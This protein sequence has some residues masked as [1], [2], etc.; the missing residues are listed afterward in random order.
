MVQRWTG[1]VAASEA[2]GFV[3]YG[4]YLTLQEECN[5]LRHALKSLAQE[6]SKVADELFALSQDDGKIERALERANA[7]IKKMRAEL[8]LKIRKLKELDNANALENLYSVGLRQEN[9]LNALRAVL[10][11]LPESQAEMLQE[12][13]KL[14]AELDAQ[15]K[16][17]NYWMGEACSNHNAL[18]KLI[19]QEPV[20]KV[21]LTEKLSLPCLQWLDLTTQFTMLHGQLLYPAPGAQPVKA[22]WVMVPLTPSPEMIIAGRNAQCNTTFMTYSQDYIDLYKAMLTA[23]PK[24]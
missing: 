21:I 18:V 1:R 15:T 22:G 5:A 2:G 3:A 8:N 9:E 23:I 7:E 14:R 12:I 6:F 13:K 10:G 11:D 16:A 19:Q 20:A 4:D 24:A 17:A